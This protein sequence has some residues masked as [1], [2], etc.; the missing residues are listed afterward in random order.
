M[1]RCIC[2]SMMWA[3]AA[4][5]CG[6][7]TDDAPTHI[8]VP[9]GVFPDR[10]EPVV[11]AG[12][13]TPTTS[14]HAVYFLRDGLLVELQRPLAAPVFLDAPLNNLLAG[15][16]PT[17]AENGLES[18][19]PAGTEVVDVQLLRNN[20]VSIHL[21]EVFFEVEGAQR[22]RAVAQLVLTASALARDSQG[23]LFF[24]DGV[25]QSLPD[26]AGTIAQVRPGELPRVLRVDDFSELM[27]LTPL[28]SV[29]S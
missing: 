18:A 1:L 5:A 29:S 10:N 20:V 2:V 14:L 13:D 8:E 15:P 27:P 21:N 25:A 11:G 16:T 7:P 17:E 26:G 28:R 22:V 23:V 3:L 4:A 24:L 6:L 9:A 19:I 12:P